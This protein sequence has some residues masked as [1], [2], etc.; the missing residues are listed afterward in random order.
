MSHVGL[1]YKQ[2]WVFESNI[3]WF[4]KCSASECYFLMKQQSAD[5]QCLI[6]LEKKHWIV[7]IDLLLT[8]KLGLLF[9]FKMP[10]PKVFIAAVIFTASAFAV[11]VICTQLFW[12]FLVSLLLTQKWFQLSIFTKKLASFSLYDLLS[13]FVLSI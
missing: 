3:T 2:I 7:Y 9:P 6:R 10:L 5:P 11:R 4:F 8:K 12:S 13:S 1:D